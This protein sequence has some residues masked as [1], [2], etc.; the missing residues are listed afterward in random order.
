MA[1]SY[2][3]IILLCRVVQAVFSKLSSNRINDFPLLMKYT[4]FSNTISAVLGI[5]LIIIDGSGFGVDIYTFVIA[6]FSGV[7]LFFSTF[8]SIYGMKSGSVSAC[9]MFS[10]AG[11]IVPL[12]AGNILFNQSVNLIQWLGVALF[13]VSARLLLKA[14]KKIN[15]KFSFKTILL[16]L[17]ALTS[18]GCTMLAQQLFVN[19]VPD[20]SI[21]VFSF[22]SFGVVAFFGNII[23][24]FYS[25][26]N[27]RDCAK[28]SKSL[29][30]CAVSLATAVFVIN[31]LAT[32]SARFL[33]PVVLFTF[34]NGGGTIISTIVAAIMYKEKLSIH[35]IL[36]VVSGIFALAIIKIF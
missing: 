5:F 24:L 34:I 9:S 32:A 18:N 31:Q 29:L 10:T 30:V 28:M 8:C 11:L 26:S 23:S 25:K 6:S 22:I 13:F 36:G 35:S 7:S 20:G 33:A 16:L 15:N 14:S 12:I 4:A 3:S 1:I 2:I 19:Y 17:G 27:N 21:S